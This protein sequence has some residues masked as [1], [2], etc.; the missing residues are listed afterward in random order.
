MERF[1]LYV[2]LL[3]LLSFYGCWKVRYILQSV[4]HNL[5]PSN[6]FLFKNYRKWTL[7]VAIFSPKIMRMG[8]FE[9]LNNK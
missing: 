2:G 7:V 5:A 9:L 6:V 4:L 1:M 3:L 8:V